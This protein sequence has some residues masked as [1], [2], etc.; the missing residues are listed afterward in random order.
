MESLEEVAV[1][2][3]CDAAAYAVRESDRFVIAPQIR[4]A[5][6]EAAARIAAAALTARAITRLTDQIERLIAA[7]E[8]DVASH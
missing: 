2:A 5:Y 8:K 7:A 4:I 3:A 1:I 6:I